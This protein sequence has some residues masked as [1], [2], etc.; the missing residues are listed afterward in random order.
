M[1]LLS[2][3]FG[4]LGAPQTAGQAGP[5]VANPAIENPLSLILLFAD[6]RLDAQALQQQLRAFDRSMAAALVEFE[7]DFPAEQPIGLAGWGPHVIKLIGFAAP[8]PA[9]A[10]E[11]CVAPA[12]YPAE[13]KDQ[14]RAHRAHVILYYAGDATSALDQYL[15]LA[16]VAGAL[17][18]LG[19]QI[20]VNE[21]ANTSLPAQMLADPESKGKHLKLLQAL[22]LLML[23]CGFVKYEVEGT[24]GVWMRTYGA[25]RFGLPNFAALAEG[26]DQGQ[27]YFEIFGNVLGYLQTSGAQMGEGHSMQVGEDKFFRLRAP[28]PT[29]YFLNDA[30]GLWVA[31]IIGADQINQ[32]G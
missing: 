13:L 26:H 6:L 18:H 10:L 20:V 28:N 17:S 27:W 8:M 16:A 15:A 5:L 2:R 21:T 22:P 4:K 9:D 3:F 7:P 25:D 32:P 19:A 29:E 11:A 31:E 23:F 12:H 1:S 24:P 14:A 30:K